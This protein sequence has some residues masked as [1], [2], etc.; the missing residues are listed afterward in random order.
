MAIILIVFQAAFLSWDYAHS[1]EYHVGPQQTYTAIGDIPWESLEP[2][3]KVHIHWRASNYHEK[4]AIGRSGTAL[5]P[6]VISGIPG[7]GGQLP[8]ID[9]QNATT[10]QELDYW[11]EPRGL[12]KIG[13]TST[14][15]EPIPQHII[16]E[17]LELRSARQPYSFTDDRGNTQSY[18]K[19]AAA[20]YIEIGRN[21]T[22]RNCVIHDSG[23]GIFIA[24]NQGNTRDILISGNY[25]YGNGNVNSIY[26]HNT[27]TAAIGIT[28]EY[29]FM[30]ALRPG[31]GGNN[32]KDRSAGLVVR[33][34]WIENGNRQLDL[35]DGEDTDAIVND[36]AYEK[37]YVYGNILKDEEEVGNSQIVHYGGDSGNLDKYRKGTLYFYN[38]TVISGHS[39]NTTLLRLSTN[40]EYADVFNNILFVTE[41]GA[42]F[43]LMN[44][45]GHIS[46]RNN[47]LKSGWRMSHSAFTG[48]T[49]HNSDNIDGQTPGFEAFDQSNFH[50]GENGQALD[51]GRPLPPDLFLVHPLSFEYKYHM[52][53]ISRFSDAVLDI[54]AF[55]KRVSHRR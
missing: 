52:S 34:N 46:I 41:S 20:F 39:G 5:E 11:N 54:G 44:S 31:A 17:N 1:I 36:P 10:R 30:G 19:N 14:P 29:N 51:N 47:W 25:I 38:N 23:N 2:G 12:I 7:P 16:V 40:E 9:G 6:I 13:G 42:R 35:V 18:A 53:R 3:D 43:A 26:E 48:T 33:Y 21:I 45:A 8:V 50:L 15:S 27:Y 37:T 22:L 49:V 55:V 32:L 28:Y 4:W 24:A